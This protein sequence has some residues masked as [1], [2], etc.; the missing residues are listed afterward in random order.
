[1]ELRASGVFYVA[2]KRDGAVVGEYECKNIVTGDAITDIFNTYFRGVGTPPTNYFLGL[3]RTDNFV[4]TNIADTMLS[5]SGW[6][7]YEGYSG[8]RPE[9]IH[10]ALT[11]L[12]NRIENLTDIRPFI[13]DG[14]E[15]SDVT[16]VFMSTSDTKGGTTGLLFAASEQGILLNDLI[17]GDEIFVRY[18][19]EM[20]LTFEEGYT[21]VLSYYFKGT[22]R[23]T[24]FYVGLSD[25][26][27]SMAETDTLS[28]HPGWT[29]NTDYAG[30][31]KLVTFA[32]PTI[33]K[34]T[35]D[36]DTDASDFG[37]GALQSIVTG[38]V[39]VLN[40]NV[41]LGDLFLTTVSSGTA[42][43]L[44]SRFELPFSAS[45]GRIEEIFTFSIIFS[46]ETTES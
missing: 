7:E 27:S 29:E 36:F 35:A 34:R 16:G 20:N 38:A 45:I 22:A 10:D 24:S 8:N 46:L 32:T 17:A 42:G 19:L 5:H 11:P 14:N 9:W 26:V 30:S 1:M 21:D 44:I 33:E 4:E 2:H 40:D 43:L 23:P 3:I 13:I 37:T 31:R 41:S 25:S 15:T 18:R 39:F 28:S 12:N 6:E